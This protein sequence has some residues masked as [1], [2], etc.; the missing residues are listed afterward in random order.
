MYR[1]SECHKLYE[2]C[3][4]YCEC[5]N[6]I[7]E[8]IQ[9]KEQY[10]N[11]ER[12]SIRPK[13][14]LTQEEK[15]EIEQEEK[16]KN[17][18]KIVAIISVIISLLILIA[19]PYPKKKIEKVQDKVKVSNVKIPDVSAFWDNTLPS[20]YRKSDDV[21]HLPLINKSLDLIPLALHRYLENIGQDFSS[22]WNPTSSTGKGECRIQ[23]TINR[24]GLINHG[25]IVSSS[26]NE[27]F[28]DTVLLVLSKV[29]KVEVPPESYKGERIILS[30]K[31]YE[32]GSQKVYFPDFK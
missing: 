10:E 22:A 29:T 31:I 21:N 26:R 1:C 2:I 16:E 8:T 25:K 24:E 19:P 20:E 32:N 7:F 11:I 28:D 27:A 9:E 13:K 14:Q 15:E 17:N 18:A 6:D 4:D 3:P 5:G 30:F 23:F 12:A